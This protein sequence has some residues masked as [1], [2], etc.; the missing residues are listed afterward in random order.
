M[1]GK[2]VSDSP[3]PGDVVVLQRGDKDGWQGH[4]GFYMGTN[5]DGT[6]KVLGGNQGDAVAEGNFDASKVLGFRRAG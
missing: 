1:W 3:Q 6:I 2:D 5:P 4:V